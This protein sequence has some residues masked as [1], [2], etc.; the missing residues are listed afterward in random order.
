MTPDEQYKVQLASRIAAAQC[1]TRGKPQPG[2]V[3]YIS[4]LM[5]KGQAPTPN[6]DFG[7]WDANYIRANGYVAPILDPDYPEADRK[8]LEGCLSLPQQQQL[9]PI[10]SAYQSTQASKEL[11]R[12]STQAYVSTLRDSRFI[13]LRKALASCLAAKNYAVDAQSDLGGV[14]IDSTWTPDRALRAALAEAECN[15]QLTLTQSAVLIESEYEDEVVAM[16]RPLLEDTRRQSNARV[17]YAVD[18]LRSAG[19][20]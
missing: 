12:L 7:Y 10:S 15:D 18:L 16:N 2:Y 20:R 3:Q 9:Q 6:W 19:V 8:Q 5:T 14:E 1:T 4:Q 13:E 11:S 17:R